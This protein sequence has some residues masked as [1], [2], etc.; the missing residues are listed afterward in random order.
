MSISAQI[1]RIGRPPAFSPKQS[2][3][4]RKLHALGYSPQMLAERFGANVSTIK[5]HLGLNAKQ[6][7]NSP[8]Y[9]PVQPLRMIV[10]PWFV[11]IR[12]GLPTRVV[13]AAE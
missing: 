2:V 1:E 4:I 13:R 8:A 3:Q 5:R 9:V 10:T 6:A 11:D 7:S 12:D